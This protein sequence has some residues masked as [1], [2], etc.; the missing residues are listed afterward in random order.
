MFSLEFLLFK[1]GHHLVMKTLIGK[2]YKSA[3]HGA[4]KFIAFHSQS[5]IRELGL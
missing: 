5:L 3:C 4:G 1:E 2:I